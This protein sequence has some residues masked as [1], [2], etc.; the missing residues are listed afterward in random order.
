MHPINVQI[1]KRKI[2]TTYEYNDNEIFDI[3]TFLLENATNKNIQREKL[4]S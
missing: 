3:E 1:H 2:N 4:S